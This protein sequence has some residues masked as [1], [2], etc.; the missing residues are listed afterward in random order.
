MPLISIVIPV[1]NVERYVSLCL[2]S[3]R[4]QTFSDIEII[5]VVDGA[6]DRSESVVRMHEALDERVRVISKE[7]GGVSSARNAGIRAASGKYIMFVDPDDCLD[8]NACKV[9]FDTFQKT[10]AEV[11]TFGA[12][13]LPAFD[14]N[15]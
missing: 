7:N 5:C 14:G 12:Q 1:Y 11:V 9:V 10:D 4:A 15:A 3:L 13:C 6:L 8:K 2:D